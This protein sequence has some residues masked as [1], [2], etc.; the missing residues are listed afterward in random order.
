MINVSNE[1][2]LLMN[3]RSDFKQNAVITFADGTELN[4]T[5]KDF[6]ISNNN[7][8]DAS[9]TNGIPL[10]VAVCRNIQ[11]ELMNDDDRFSTYDFFGAVI[12]LY[13]T[14]Q[15]S[16]TVER[17]EY[18]TFTVLAPETYG[19]TVIITA[20]DDMYK[21]D[22]EYTTTLAFPATIGA[23]LRDACVTLGISQGTTTFLND[24]FVVD[25]KPEGLTF[26]Q[27]FGHI[28]MIAGGN[29]RIDRTGRLR[30][31]TYDFANMESI[32]AS[33]LNGGSYK[34]WD[35]PVNI[36]GGSFAP[37]NGGDSV[38]GGTF[39][40]RSS[41]HVLGN[42]SN[43]KID[44][45]DVVITG[46][47][48]V[49]RDAEN[50]EHVVLLG[51]EGYVL[52]VDN[53]LISGKEAQAL[54]L[55]GNVM[56]GGFFRQFSGDIVA[57]PTCE[58][59]DPAVVLDRKGNIYISFL[60]DVN[61]Q[62][63][64]FTSI[65]NSAEPALRNSAKRYSESAQTFIKAREL[66]AKE[67]KAREQAVEQL[68]KDLSSSSGLYVS[69]EIQEDGSTI[70]YMH[71]KPTLKKSMIVW[72]L[73]SLAF[74]ISTDGG[75]TYPYGFTVDG[76]TITR[77]LYAEGIDVENL[78]VGENVTMG[79][80]AT[81]SWSKV[82]DTENIATK[83]FVTGQGYQKDIDVTKIT[84]DTVTAP[85]IATLGLTVGNEIKMGENATISWDKVTGTEGIA[86][87]S[88]VTGQG[89][90]NSAEA[91][92]IT[93]NTITTAYVNALNVKAGSVDAENITGTTITGKKLSGATGDFS[94]KITAEDGTIGGFNI[95]RSSIYKSKSSLYSSTSGVY[96]G[97]DGI[98]VGYGSTTGTAT[99]AVTSDGKLMLGYNSKIQCKGDIIFED[100][101]VI[102]YGTSGTNHIR[103]SSDGIV[104]G[105]Y[106]GKL[107]FFSA[108]N[109]G[110]T[111]K[112]V[113]TITTTSS[114]TASTV[115]TKLNELINALKAYNLIG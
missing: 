47:R 59:M 111:K 46:M 41:F 90:I 75:A 95:T 14:F 6:T 60:T 79:P 57:N 67:K 16:E 5:E 7:V 55:I 30:V 2:Q 50:K 49:Y 72:K 26:R 31:V 18:G 21:A 3:E 76:E 73:T 22:K 34:P 8:V 4:L 66:V 27:I 37:W 115:A 71:D 12:R 107:G 91:T 96:I 51:E 70:Y 62:F 92:S 28:A 23:M 87:K 10:G 36:D 80:N 99:F 108:S 78:V 86:E 48:T 61:F 82:T 38:D 100:T 42:W 35:N 44:T 113:S 106:G 105:G 64:G 45:D 109:A 9:E 114:A 93:K 32:Y 29:I 43:L 85:Y 89:Y 68:A 97:E 110:S 24:D 53:P 69:T 94:G 84:K 104:V 112:T 102:K 56:I 81:I 74:G 54:D 25:E 77:L 11:I 58:F 103:F 65:K 39:G 83:D 33:V 19:E 98:A 1:F 40:D 15:L 88:F 20:L 13:L 52:S 17:I 101:C 63:F